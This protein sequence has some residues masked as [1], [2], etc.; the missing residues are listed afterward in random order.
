MN[1]CDSTH[2][3][4]QN[5]ESLRLHKVP[6]PEHWIVEG[7]QLLHSRTLS[8]IGLG[9]TLNIIGAVWTFAYCAIL[10]QPIHYNLCYHFLNAVRKKATNYHNVQFNNCRKSI[11]IFLFYNSIVKH[12]TF[13]VYHHL[14]GRGLY[15]AVTPI[16]L[17]MLHYKFTMDTSIASITICPILGV[18]G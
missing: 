1:H 7:L 17:L 12:L 8:S 6:I 4:F 2:Y 3:T 9:S 18:H 14:D 5:T 10:K 16:A 11:D 15:S 13:Q